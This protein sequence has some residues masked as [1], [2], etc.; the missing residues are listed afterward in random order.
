[1]EFPFEVRVSPL[2]VFSGQS[3]SLYSVDHRFNRYDNLIITLVSFTDHMTH[4]FY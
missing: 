4:R 3:S 1:M 2:Q